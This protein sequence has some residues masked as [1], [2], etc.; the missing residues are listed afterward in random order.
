[1]HWVGG[2]YAPG[3]APSDAFRPYN[4]LRDF[5]GI[6]YVGKVTA[7]EV[8]SDRPN[9]PARRRVLRPA[10]INSREQTRFFLTSSLSE[11]PR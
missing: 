5:D 4:I 11:Y 7:D 3:T 6:I 1:M 10:D 2:L 8:P 9:V